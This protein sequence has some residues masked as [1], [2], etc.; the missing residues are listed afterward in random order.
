MRLGF[1]AI[2]CSL[3]I[4]DLAVWLLTA[5]WLGRHRAPPWARYALHAFFTVQLL[6]VLCLVVLVVGGWASARRHL[7]WVP[8]W[9]QATIY[10]WHLVFL[11][12]SVIGW[13]V[14]GAVNT[15]RRVAIRQTAAS[16]RLATADEADPRAMSRRTL[17]LASL[18]AVPPL[19]SVGATSYGLVQS[20]RFRTRQQT[21][22][23]PGLPSALDG[24]RIAHVS[25]THIGRWSTPEFIENLVGETN[26]MEADVVLF[27]GD[28]LDISIE[29]LPAG[30][31]MIKRLRARQGLY[32]IEGNHDLIDSGVRFRYEVESSGLNFL[33]GTT[34]FIEHRGVPVQLLGLPWTHDEQLMREHVGMVA[35]QRQAGAFPILLAHH[36]HA[37]DAAAEAGLPLVLSGHT[38]GGQ[39][40]LTRGINAGRLL[41]RYVSGVYQKPGSTLLV[42]NGAGNW[43][44]FRVNAPAEIIALTLRAGVGDDR[45]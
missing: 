9:V 38:H 30:I 24:F 4:A 13:I 32:M 15:V 11:P 19:L 17:L 41:F 5:V 40:A 10:I 22:W 6:Y 44:P 39:I 33:R 37:F 34:A 26:A 8:L 42:S 2:I 28:L 36:P 16:A 7:D 27:T 3:V 25:D 29:D 18:A 23:I 45:Q 12:L 1:F 31:A 43:L 14:A 20:R 21:L 35:Q